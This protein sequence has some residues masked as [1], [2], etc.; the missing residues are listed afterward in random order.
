VEY[1]VFSGTETI[2]SKNP[3]VDKVNTIPRGSKSLLDALRLFRKFDYALATNPSDRTTIWAMLASRKALGFRYRQ[4]HEWWKRLVLDH[5]C[6]YDDNGHAVQL[7]LSLLEPLGIQAVPSVE[8]HFDH[9]DTEFAKSRLPSSPYVIL[10]PYSRGQYKYWSPE[11]WGALAGII[12]LQ[13]ACVPV[14]TVTFDPRD[15]EF[16]DAILAHAPEG[17]LTFTEPF[18]FSQLAAAIQ[19]STAYVGIDTVVTHI[20]TAVGASTVALF[21]PTLTRY[22]APWPNDCEERS[23]FAANRGIQRKGNIT[24]VQKDWE[25]V[26]CNRQSCRISS[27][28]RMECME[29]ISPEEVLREIIKQMKPGESVL[30]G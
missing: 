4:R 28:G 13:T 2:L 20:A 3:Y 10:H 15:R 7:V 5:C 8:M 25:C 17:C 26:P 23:P 14:F 1:L 9:E 24:V 30:S 18:T 12:R 11:K 16:L 19:G 29:A 22:W 21:G 27:R 6:H